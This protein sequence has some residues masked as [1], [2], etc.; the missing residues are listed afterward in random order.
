M[1]LQEIINE[2]FGVDEFQKRRRGELHL[3]FD[4]EVPETH[5]R[6]MIKTFKELD[7][8]EKMVRFWSGERGESGMSIKEKAIPL[9]KKRLPELM[10]KIMN[11][12]LGPGEDPQFFGNDDVGW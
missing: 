2:E 1:K 7:P 8:R 5:L 6:D 12:W 4:W 11:E 3:S 9:L 10:D